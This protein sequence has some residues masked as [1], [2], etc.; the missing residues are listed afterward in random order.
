M[1]ELFGKERDAI[2]SGEDR[3]PIVEQREQITAEAKKRGN[4]RPSADAMAAA[5]GIPSR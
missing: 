3:Q 4:K 2:K 1:K 5:R